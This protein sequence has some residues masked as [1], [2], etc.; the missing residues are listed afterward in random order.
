MEL[1]MARTALVIEDEPALAMLL[2]EHLK[3]WGFSPTLLEVG[4]PAVGWVREHRPDVILLDLLLPDI[5]G[6]EICESLKLDRETNLI[7]IIM[8]TALCQR[9]D[10]IHGL[11]VGANRYLTKPFTPEDLNHAVLDA[12]RWREDLQRTGSEGEIHFHLQSDTRYLEELN[13]LLAA[14]FHFT[15]L[16]DSQIKQLTIAVRELGTNAIEWGH[17]KQVDRIVTVIYRIHPLQVTIDIR[18]TGP[19]FNP[20]DVPHAARPEDPLGHLE[21]RHAL[22]LGAGGYG[23]LIARGLVDDLQFNKTGNQVRLVKNFSPRGKADRIGTQ[24]VAT[25]MGN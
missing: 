4:K 15:G 14:L 21:V 10:M 18:D 25:V 13:Q 2:A 24:N 3:G 6:F 16:S 7:P 20:D 23:I 1:R 11:Q 22:G 8:V 9:K 19:G 5:D 17:R 12:C